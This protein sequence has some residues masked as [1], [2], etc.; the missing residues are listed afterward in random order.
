MNM[1]IRKTQT[2]DTDILTLIGRL[3]IVT[4]PKLEEAL[5]E[6]IPSSEKVELDFAGVDYVSSAGLRVLLLGEKNTKAAGKTMT[7]KNVSR[8]VMKVFEIA[9]FSGILT[10]I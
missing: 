9:G 3:D 7:L 2:G 10:I 6:L 4:A 5:L 1:E 8:E